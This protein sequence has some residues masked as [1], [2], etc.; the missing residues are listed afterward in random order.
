MDS[1]LWNASVQTLFI[2]YFC[3]YCQTKRKKEKKVLLPVGVSMPAA[4]TVFACC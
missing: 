3:R 1:R 2:V 4:Y